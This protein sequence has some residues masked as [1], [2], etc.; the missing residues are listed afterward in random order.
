MD[1]NLAYFF[2]TQGFGHIIFIK[3]IELISGTLEAYYSAIHT[4]MDIVQSPTPGGY[5]CLF[6]IS[7]TVDKLKK[8]TKNILLT[9]ALYQNQ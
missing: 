3:Y 5:H 1:V 7:Y 9:D 6:V 2:D 4:L 8:S